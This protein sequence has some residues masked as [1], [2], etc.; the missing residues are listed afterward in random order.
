M[1]TDAWGISH[2]WLDDDEVEQHPSE[3]TVRVLREVIGEPP[4][5]LEDRAPLV[6]V[7]GDAVDLPAG[8]LACEDGT[9]LRVGGR[10]EELSLGYHELRP[11]DG[12]VRR[13]IVSPGRC[14]QPSG[15]REWG[16]A[17]QL[18]AARSRDSWGVGDL[19]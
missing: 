4:E 19:A 15:L 18:Y 6:I 13:V 9:V 10:A 12:P 17:V 8:E 7:V 16:L 11:T 3:D 1:S 5:D 14:H 2:T